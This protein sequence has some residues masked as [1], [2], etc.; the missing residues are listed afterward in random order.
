MRRLALTLALVGLVACGDDDAPV[1]DGSIDAED[2]G[3]ACVIVDGRGGA[4]RFATID[5]AL[6]SGATRL[7]LTAGDFAPPSEAIDGALEISGVLGE[8]R[9]DGSF[10]CVDVSL[11]AVLDEPARGASAAVIALRGDARVVLRELEIRGCDVGVYVEGGELLAERITT[12]GVDLG[13]LG[14]GPTASVTL[15]EVRA[16][17]RNLQPTDRVPFAGG[18]G[19]LEG[20]RLTIEGAR[21]EGANAT[22]GLV[23]YDGPL[24]VSDLEIVGG[25]GGF[26]VRGVEASPARMANV[27]VSE[28]RAVRVVDEAIAANVVLGGSVRIEALE[29]RGIEGHGLVAREGASLE[30]DGVLAEDV[31]NIAFVARAGT[32]VTLDASVVRRSAVGVGSEAGGELTLTTSATM[33]QVDV[34]IAVYGGGIVNVPA[35]TTFAVTSSSS[36][37]TTGA[38]VDED[39]TLDLRAGELSGFVLGVL[40]NGSA[41]LADV[42]ITDSGVGI[43]ASAGTTTATDVVVDGA[44]ALGVYSTPEGTVDLTR[45]RVARAGVG[46]WLRGG[47]H[48]F[49]DVQV[50]QSLG[51]GVLLDEAA[52]LVAQGGAI[53]ESASRGVEARAGASLELRGAELRANVDAAL[54]IYDASAQVSGCTFGGT[55][56]DASGRADELRAVAREGEVSV[57]VESSQFDL[58]VTRDCAVGRCTL[59]LGEGAGVAGIVRPNCLVEG[60]ATAA[61][62][63]VVDQDGATFTLEGDP[64][65]STLLAGRASDLGLVTGVLS[66]R[67]PIPEA[68]TIPAP[69]DEL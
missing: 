44:R 42:S 69:T 36:D 26:L 55:L 58:D 57:V 65:W 46:A 43:A 60:A 63:T 47:A 61:V 17:A 67:P 33:E 48:R 32:R 51:V 4:D 59:V 10:G 18:L 41:T 37:V 68:P 62:R 28:L 9:V 23:A 7:C 5:E 39:G 66:T 6:S 19:A 54:A 13:V 53:R 40:N 50:L 38:F 8:T 20:A 64:T 21:V 27:R 1:L 11:P 24:D 25:L 34:G 12:S 45:T 14:V 22:L 15:R 30:V 52:A 31:R 49:T 2:G 35:T 56:P 16:I 29:L 3:E